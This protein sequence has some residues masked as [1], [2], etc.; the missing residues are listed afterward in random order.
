MR[1]TKRQKK[2]VN[3]FT[4]STSPVRPQSL[5]SIAMLNSLKRANSS[6]RYHVPKREGVWKPCSLTRARCPD[7]RKPPIQRKRRRT[8][9][10]RKRK[11]HSL[12]TKRLRI[13][14]RTPEYTKS[15]L[16]CRDSACSPECGP[17]W[18]PSSHYRPPYLHL[19]LKRRRDEFSSTP[20]PICK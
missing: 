17:L 8:H 11:L 13:G 15:H 10:K 4:S 14:R 16:S 18:T 5:S 1:S 12:H 9:T 19:A 3:N 2:P 6:A 20:R 7:F